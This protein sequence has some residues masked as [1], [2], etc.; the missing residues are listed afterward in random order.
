MPWACSLRRERRWDKLHCAASGAN[1]DAHSRRRR[2]RQLRLRRFRFLPNTSELTQFAVLG[3]EAD[4]ATQPALTGDGFSV[5]YD[6][7]A[8]HYVMDVPASEPGILYEY[9]NNTPNATWSGGHAS[10]SSGNWLS[11]VL[12]LKPTSPEVQLTYT[13][14][15]NYD[16]SGMSPEPFGWLAFG[17]PTAAGAVPVAGSASYSAMV[18]GSSLDGNGYILGSATLDFDFA[19]GQLSGHFTPDYLPLSGMGETYALGRYDFVN[20]IFGVGS[21]AFSG[22]LSHSTL[23]YSG[24]FNGLFTGPAAQELMAR[25]TATFRDPLTNQDSTMFGVWVGAD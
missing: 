8:G 15:V 1:T 2:R 6:G 14:M 11:S 10:D 19:A 16:A 22:G 17:T 9:A 7:S 13:T 24:S 4:R 25:W 21:T 23:P 12:V 3:Y 20:T 18:R 5:R